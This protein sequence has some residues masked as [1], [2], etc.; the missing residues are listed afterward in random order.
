MAP[1]RLSRKPSTASNGPTGLRKGK[2][3]KV[4]QQKISNRHDARIMETLT[5]I[6]AIGSVIGVS[7]IL[8]TNTK[9]GKKWLQDL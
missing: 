5:I 1:D 7:L 3:N 9:K 4:W 2:R 6:F 8:W